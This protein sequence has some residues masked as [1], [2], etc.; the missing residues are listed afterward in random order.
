MELTLTIPITLHFEVIEIEENYLPSFKVKTR[1][2]IPHPTGKPM[3]SVEDIWFECVTWDAF[4]KKLA[5]LAQAEDHDE[6]SLS[7]M[8]EGLV[9]SLMLSENRRSCIFRIQ[10]KEPETGIGY[11]RTSYET[12]IPI[13]DV[14]SIRKKFSDFPIWW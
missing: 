13:E 11:L 9:I 12:T 14:G 8:S 2:E 7:D 5:G 4:I 10:T 1:F 6:A 3:Y